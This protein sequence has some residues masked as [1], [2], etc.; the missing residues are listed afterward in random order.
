MR[1]KTDILRQGVQDISLFSLQPSARLNGVKEV[2]AAVKLGK[3]PVVGGAE[4][5]GFSLE[6]VDPGAW[7]SRRAEL[8]VETNAKSEYKNTIVWLAEADDAVD[9]LIREIVRSEK[10]V[11]EIPDERQVD[12]DV[13][14]FL[15]AERRLAERNRELVAKALERVL[16]DGTLIFR[17]KPT[18]AREAGA[19]LQAAAQVILGQAATQVFQYYSLVP[20][21][22]A[23]D[24]AAKF[25]AVERLDR[26][27][28]E[29]DP[30]GLVTKKGGAAR[31][32]VSHPALAEVL[33]VF[34]AKVDESGSGRLHG[35]YL[36]DLFSA[37]SYGWSKD[38]VRYLFA[39][40]LIAGEIELHIPTADG[41]VRTP[42]PLA[43]AA[44]KS[45]VAFNRVG[46]ALRDSR[47]SPEAL[48]RAARRLEQL[49]GVEV[50]PLEDHVS[51]VVQKHLPGVLEH[52][53]ALPDRLRLLDLSGE[54]RASTL[55]AAATDLL[56]GDAGDAAATLGGKECSTPEDIQWARAI[57]TALNDGAEAE[58]R[59]AR[60]LLEA[61][62]ELESL[63]PEQAEGSL[64]EVDRETVRTVL[65]S[66]TFHLQ[67]PDLRSALRG[68]KLD[69][70][71]GSGHFLLYCF[72]LLETIYEEAYEDPDIGLALKSKYST[73]ADLRKAVPDLILRYN[74]HGIDIDLRATQIAALALWLRA[75][76][77]Y[78]QLGLRGTERPKITKSNIVCAEPM[79]GETDMLR[80]F[81][82]SLT[83]KV[84][85]QLVEVV[86]DR[87]KLAGEAGSLL[88][89]EEEIRDTVAAAKRQWLEG[90]KYEQITLFPQESQPKQEQLR[91]FDVS[92]ITD[93]EFWTQ[94]EERVLEELRA[95]AESAENGRTFQRRL[96]A[97]DAAQGFAFVDMCRKRFDVVLMNP[98]FGEA[99]KPSKAYLEKN[100]PRTKNDVYAAFV[101]RGLQLLQPGGMLGAITSRTGFFLSSF[102]KWR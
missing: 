40:L 85:G 93:E 44:L 36:Q 65:A 2:K 70:A 54:E 64:S 80:E 16:L 5:I 94:A 7:D 53:A 100:Y 33:R 91:L 56:R 55:H 45:T 98:P 37:A 39:A 97:E 87:M 58:I 29:L 50:L 43:I 57:V 24:A 4:E 42:G 69:P 77:T 52:I 74:L 13:A 61:L 67:L 71:C 38:A 59:R 51:R 96:F 76:R 86:F 21:R 82:A 22:P 92:G 27:P 48:D 18:P 10:V 90:P 47:P 30:L 101:E 31:V 17:G 8:L 34:R 26:I 1:V 3:S 28:K 19:S 68:L 102:Q 35:N 41:P 75:Q 60:R 23:T 79:P 15:R 78:Q 12:R 95:Y 14:Q 84:L 89:I 11:G 32:D 62:E 88:K 99:S 49:F 73:L 66:D 25:I 20:I 9:D 46:I 6:F 81:T 72:D 63:F 83:P